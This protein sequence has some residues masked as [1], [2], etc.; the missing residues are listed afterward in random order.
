MHG[1]QSEGADSFEEARAEVGTAMETD[2]AEVVQ[3]ENDRNLSNSTVAEEAPE[4]LSEDVMAAEFP[5][6]CKAVSKATGAGLTR[7]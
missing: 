2:A 5:A 1:A 3:G 4:G 7:G 6:R